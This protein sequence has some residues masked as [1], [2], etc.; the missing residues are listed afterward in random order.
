MQLIYLL[1]PPNTSNLRLK[2]HNLI[3]NIP[4]ILET[5]NVA[6][7]IV[8]YY[9]CGYYHLPHHILPHSKQRYHK[10]RYY[11]AA[12]NDAADNNAAYEAAKLNDRSLMGGG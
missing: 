2:L 4:L 11:I 1:L 6:H 7:Y 10:Q 5:D 9:R 12:D 8:R 3:H